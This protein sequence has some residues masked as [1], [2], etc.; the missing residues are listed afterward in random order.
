MQYILVFTRYMF[1]ALFQQFHKISKL[2]TKN[3]YYYI[4]KGLLQ[5]SAIWY[6]ARHNI[7]QYSC[8][9]PIICHNIQRV[10]DNIWIGKTSEIVD[11]LRHTVTITVIFSLSWSKTAAISGTGTACSVGAP[12]LNTDSCWPL[13]GFCQILEECSVLWQLILIR[14]VQVQW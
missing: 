9:N 5:A 1:I 12:E 3:I 11:N 14:L 2:I 4:I 13:I 6:I 8:N 10:G 7:H